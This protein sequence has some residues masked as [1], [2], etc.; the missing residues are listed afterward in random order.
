MKNWVKSS[1][2]PMPIQPCDYFARFSHDLAA[3]YDGVQ[4]LQNETLQDYLLLLILTG[5]RRQ[6]AAMMKWQHVDLSAKTLTVTDTKN[7][8]S[9]SLLLT[10]YLHELLTLRSQNQINDYVFPGIG[11]AGNIIEPGK[12]MVKVTNVSGVQFTVHDLHRTFITI[13]EGLDI[14]AYALKRLMNHKMNND[15]TTGYIVTD[16][17]QRR[18]PMQQINNYILK[19]MG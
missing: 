4:T 2:K 17:E 7:H 10:D 5:L 14:S 11:A 16:V 9:H 1:A 6:E 12:Q 19:C 18:N 8:E 13:A 3:W 15:I